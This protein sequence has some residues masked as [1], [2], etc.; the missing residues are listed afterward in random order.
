MNIFS[1]MDEM[2]YRART[3]RSAKNAGIVL[4]RRYCHKCG[5]AKGTIGGKL[6]RGTSRHNPSVFICGECNAND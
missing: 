3:E 4:N 2:E 6:T 5:K 1:P